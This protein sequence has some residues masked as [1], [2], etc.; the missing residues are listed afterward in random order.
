M[1]SLREQ[2]EM[3]LSVILINR[4]RGMLED[5]LVKVLRPHIK[6]K[7]PDFSIRATL[8][9]LVNDQS[10]SLH[11]LTPNGAYYLDENRSLQQPIQ[12][13]DIGS[14]SKHPEGEVTS[15][16]LPTNSMQVQSFQT[17]TNDTS[18]HLGEAWVSVDSD[19]HFHPPI[20]EAINA[21]GWDVTYSLHRGEKPAGKYTLSELNLSESSQRY[22]SEKYKGQ[23]YRHQ[24]EAI[25]EY[26]FGSN[27]CITT[28]TASGKSL[29]FQVAAIEEFSRNPSAKIIAIYPMKALGR[30]QAGRWKEAL[31]ISGIDATVEIID[32][33][34][35]KSIRLQN[36]KSAQ[37]LIMT[38]DI[39]HAWMLTNLNEP[40]VRDFL[41]GV[42]LIV[43]DEVHT[44]TGVFGSHSAF[45]FRRLQHLLALLGAAPRYV[46]A[47]ATIKNPHKHLS[48][49]FGIRFFIISSEFDT[50]PRQPMTIHFCQRAGNDVLSGLVHLI[51]E[52]GKQQSSR[53]IAFAD[54]RKQVELIASII[55]RPK[56][57]PEPDTEHDSREQ[58]LS[59]DSEASEIEDEDLDA[60]ESKDLLEKLHVL[61]YRSGYE[62][63]DRS[64]IQARLTK[65]TLRGVVSTSALELGIDIHDLDTC[66]L[67]GVPKST[68]SLFQRIGRVGR[69][70]RGTVLILNTGDVFDQT[71]FSDPSSLFNRP[72]AESTL[73][74]DNIYIQYIHALCLAR[75]GGE[76][77]KL[78]AL[79]MDS[80]EFV[81]SVNWPTGFVDLCNKERAGQISR[82]LQLKKID[83]GDAP[84]YEFP[85]RDIESQFKVEHRAGM[86]THELGSLSFSQVMR[87]AYPG[88]VY[89][90]ATQAFR[91][92]R[93]N[94]REKKI[95]VKRSKKYL[96]RPNMIP[97][98]IYPNFTE[99]SVFQC[100][101]HG[102]LVAL[103][104]NAIA[105]EYVNGFVESRGASK[106]QH[107]YPLQVGAVH[108]DQPLFSRSF[109]T[110]AVVISHPALNNPSVNCGQLARLLLEAF[111]LIV[112]F[113]KQDIDASSD[114]LRVGLPMLFEK[115]DRFIAVYDQT[116]GSLR[117]SGRLLDDHTLES[118][119]DEA[120]SMLKKQTIIQL[121]LAT[122]NALEL[123]ANA[124]K[125]ERE[126]LQIASGEVQITNNC[127]RVILPGSKGL[128]IHTHQEMHVEKV[129][130]TKE[131]LRYRVRLNPKEGI[132]AT[133]PNPLTTDIIPIPGESL[134]GLY[135]YNT[136]ETEPLAE[137]DLH[138][139][140]VSPLAK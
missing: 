109:L 126:V 91:V 54:S 44:Y 29:A 129:F 34:V 57:L 37:V 4:D 115:S 75:L 36:L 1:S 60:D 30:E 84:N 63:K 21:A 2:I 48:S 140:S 102:K 22:L 131:G 125:Q 64:Q 97:T 56:G 85:L 25:R 124:A 53:F 72:L 87:E 61:P 117:L 59:T 105:T 114:S 42:S 62:E 74:L 68:T 111:Q 107:T 10:S 88:A 16:A 58:P 121:N 69:H 81:S 47:S 139:Y 137:N 89:Y 23:I 118:A 43:V 104:T 132:D 78:H 103:E 38:P 45:L 133:H 94:I 80:G 134:I 77:D 123:L 24:H 14:G 51:Q 101:R 39:I 138:N 20:I 93:V 82:D 67:V 19:R 28:S 27:V 65:G 119:L 100:Y 127:D 7:Y 122:Q 108:Y 31:S 128:H 112:P 50:S 26:L 116:Y 5:E 52:L 73:Y 130:L 96:T 66:I 136:A 86:S 17:E 98:R 12:G 9:E 95:V 55:S 49:L 41:R 35:Q 11:R 18:S 113:E 110:S 120:C 79:G 8:T 6:G 15:Q 33:S 40:A 92:Y 83:A 76:H 3:A 135:N 13:A 99:D 70:T 90:Y 46:C 71:V 32:G 106:Y